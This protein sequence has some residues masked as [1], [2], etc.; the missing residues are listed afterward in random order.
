MYLIPLLA[1]I[2]ITVDKAL[3]KFECLQIMFLKNCLLP[4]RYFFNLLSQTLSNSTASGEE[5]TA[6]IASVRT[7]AR[8]TFSVAVISHSLLSELHT[9]A[10]DSCTLQHSGKHWSK[11]SWCSSV[12]GCLVTDDFDSHH[13]DYSCIAGSERGEKIEG[14]LHQTFNKAATLTDKSY[15]NKD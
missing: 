12:W 6:Q 2:P 11:L 3:H 9:C 14:N 10:L 1:A 7:Q 5:I 15:G 8:Q 4:E 13:L